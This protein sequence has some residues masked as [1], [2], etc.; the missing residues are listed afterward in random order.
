MTEK[1]LKDYFSGIV[2]ADVLNENLVD[3]VSRQRDVSYYKITDMDSGDKFEVT[4]DHLLKVCLDVINN[5]IKIEY[6]DV[7]SFALEASDYFTWNIETKEGK[8]V[9][10][11]LSNWSTSE[12]GTPVTMEYIKY[13][14]YYLETG[15]HR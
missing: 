8:R 13:C 11:A 10:D 15:K 6:L 7:I 5:K 2:S 14:A 3:S 9:E 4:P 1:I 12:N